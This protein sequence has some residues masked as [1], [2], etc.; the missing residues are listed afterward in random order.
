MLL[1]RKLSLNTRKTFILATHELDLALQIADS[2][3]LIHSQGV[4]VGSP[5]DLISSDKLQ[6][7]FGNELFYFDQQNKGFSIR[8]KHQ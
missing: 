2:I 5:D 1:L 7:I 3:W 8:I 4:T 6:Q